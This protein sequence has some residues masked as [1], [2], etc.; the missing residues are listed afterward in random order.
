MAK[1]PP[2]RAAAVPQ[3]RA[4][5][6]FIHLRTEIPGPTSR[7][8]QSRRTAAVAA[9]LSQG[10]PV[11]VQTARGALLTDVDGNRF[12]DLAGGIGALN[13]GHALP[14]VVRGLRRQANRY[15]HVC[16]QVVMH[17]PYLELCEMLQQVTPGAFA[18]KT[19]LFNT[20][21]EAVENAVKIARAATRR[22]AVI[23]FEHGFHGRTL[24]AMSLTSKVHP[25]K[26]GFGPF[27]P[28]VYR[29]PYP[30]AYRRPPG[31]SEADFITWR[32][33][34][35]PDFFRLHLDPA[36][37]AAVIMELQ[38]G[39]GGFVPAPVPY[40]QALHELCRQHGI[41]FI[42]DEVQTG[43]CRT[44]RFFASEHYGIEPDLIVMAKSLG[45]GMP[46]GAV[47]GRA[48][49][50]DAVPLGGLGTTFGGHPLACVAATASIH[51][52]QRHHLAEKAE[53]LGRRFRQR[54]EGVA[55]RCPA[56]GDIRGWGAMI[57]LE[58][59]KDRA[60]RAPDP[61]RTRRIVH[62]AGQRGVILLSCGAQGNVIRTLMPLA[63][64]L[65]QLDEACAV[66]EEAISGSG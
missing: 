4:P 17:E 28:E 7:R 42:A 50:L 1:G 27:A 36:Q 38:T 53:R 12:I 49:L 55:I 64:T 24:L 9:S 5:R 25:Y 2:A 15:L 59:V 58:F 37:A 19:V 23:G 47:T 63:I 39:E 8:L 44:G 29:L 41:L 18:K 43:F 6:R 45:G 31:M 51:H 13:T 35:L 57:G 26:A 34:E 20:G 33:A 22:P 65:P 48:E 11:W 62:Q 3:P 30:Y 21:A 10:S 32:I 56:L 52:L 54:M 16:S 14:A 60:S 46:L 61:D 40:V 66:I